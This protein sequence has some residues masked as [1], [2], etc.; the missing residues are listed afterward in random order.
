[1]NIDQT[2]IEF[3]ENLADKWWDEGGAFKPLHQINNLRASFIK[4]NILNHF[5][6]IK[7]LKV[8][9]IGCGGGLLSEEMAKMGCI[10][11]GIDAGKNN[12]EAAKIHAEKS[13]LDI[14]YISGELSSLNC[15]NMVEDDDKFDIILNMEVIEHVPDP[16]LFIKQS[17]EFLADN[18]CMFVSTINRTLQSLTLAKFVAEYVLRWLPIGTHKWEKFLKPKEIEMI[19]AINGL[20]IDE[21]K[22]VNF[23]PLK[24]QWYM[25]DNINV[26]YL[27]K[28]SSL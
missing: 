10:V 21:I 14:N 1:M 19:L 28:C 11:T 9:D 13:N 22:G 17:S 18:G 2:E 25:S 12:I 24:W 3:F 5:G 27:L 15:S 8:L 20:K 6:K 7:G 23:N 26:N 16:A 4:E